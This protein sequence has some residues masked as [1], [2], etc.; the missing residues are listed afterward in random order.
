MTPTVSGQGNPRCG[1]ECVS[2][3]AKTRT[4]DTR[5]ILLLSAQTGYADG[6]HVGAGEAAFLDDVHWLHHTGEC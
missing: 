5:S 2:H 3:G 1:A 6:T 4:M